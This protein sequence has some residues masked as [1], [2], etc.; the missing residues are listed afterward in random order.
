MFNNIRDPG[1]LTRPAQQ[2][3]RAQTETRTLSS[4][5]PSSPAVAAAVLCTQVRRDA[6]AAGGEGRRAAD[7][8]SQVLTIVGVHV[9]GAQPDG[10]LKTPDG[11]LGLIAEHAHG[12]GPNCDPVRV[13]EGAAV[14]NR[15]RPNFLGT[16][17]QLN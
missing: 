6:N 10:Q 4:A 11:Q 15:R 5:E 16:A 12:S 7:A 14:Q 17:A 2:L 9:T 3:A 13:E 1:N 8:P